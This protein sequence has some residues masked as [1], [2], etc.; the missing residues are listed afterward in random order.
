[1]YYRPGLHCGKEITAKL[2]AS[3]EGPLIR[4]SREVHKWV[5]QEDT[6]IIVTEAGALLMSFVLFFVKFL[7]FR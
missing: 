1:M 6:G 4:A 3:D 7:L 2:G 5:G